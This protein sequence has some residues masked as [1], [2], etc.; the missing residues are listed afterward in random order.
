MAFTNPWSNIIPA[1]GDPANTTDDEIR[2]L[3]VDID[4]RM[5]TIVGD[6]SADP[7][8]TLTGIRKT[9]HWADGVFDPLGS[10]TL[11]EGYKVFGVGL[12]P[13]A[14]STTLVWRI[15]L[16]LPVGATLQVVDARVYGDSIA[17]LMDISVVE[18]DDATPSEFVLANQ[19]VGSIT[20]WVNN[21][22]S[23]LGLV[24]AQDKPLLIKVG[25]VIA[26]GS[27]D[28]VRLFQVHYEYDVTNALQGVTP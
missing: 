24:V 5:D 27:V 19:A 2:Q 13:I 4:E 7:I 17:A 26:L 21:I 22:Q 10:D 25:M 15:N 3:R 12:H 8:V 20:G 18:A 23:G 16:K 6:W 11:T 14:T 28:A 9:V 1:G